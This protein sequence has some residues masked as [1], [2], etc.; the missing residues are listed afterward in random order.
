MAAIPRDSTR[1]VLE[2]SLRVRVVCAGTVGST[3]CWQA[4]GRLLAHNVGPLAV[5]VSSRASLLA[6]NVSRKWPLF[7]GPGVAVCKPL[8]LGLPETEAGDGGLPPALSPAPLQYRLYRDDHGHNQG[9][10]PWCTRPPRTT[11]GLC[12]QNGRLLMDHVTHINDESKTTGEAWAE[13]PLPPPPQPPT[14]PPDP[15]PPPQ[16]PVPPPEPPP[17]PPPFPPPPPASL[18]CDSSGRDSW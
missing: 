11:V 5:I 4:V 14:P 1:V 10:E 3:G 9:L 7:A 2:A 8:H 17:S 12:M 6:Q 15:P 13:P 16:P 18:T